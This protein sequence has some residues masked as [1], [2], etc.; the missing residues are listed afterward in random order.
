VIEIMSNGALNSVQDLGREENL[1]IGVCGAGAM[2]RVALALA[3]RMAG[4]APSAAGIEVCIFPFKL[5]FLASTRFACTG[6]STSIRIRD[7]TLPT[8]WT[9]RADPGDEL[10]IEP[11][12]SGARVYVAFAGGLDVPIVLGS[13]STDLKSS[14]GGMQGRAL[15]KGDRIA[16]LPVTD[17]AETGRCRAFGISPASRIRFASELASGCITLRALAGA[18]YARFSRAS[19]S[20]FERAEYRLTPDSNRQGCRLQGTALAL[21]EPLELLSHGIVPG[22]AQVPPSG[23]PIIQLAEANTCGGYPRIA[24]V[25]EADLWRIAQLRAGQRLRF[26]LVDFDAALGALRDESAE[27]QRIEQGLALAR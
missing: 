9:I 15:R 23:Q 1:D 22:T 10:L 7:R 5:R 19:R 16:F 8:W 12:G 18:E 4:N 2:D 3:N 14:F 17:A 25:I 20:A 6:A 24:T 27:Q 11:P 13:R 21:S 26:K